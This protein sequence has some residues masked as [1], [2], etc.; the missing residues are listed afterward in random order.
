MFVLFAIVALVIVIPWMVINYNQEK[1]AKDE[2][3]RLTLKQVVSELRLKLTEDPDERL[4]NIDDL[5]ILLEPTNVTFDILKRWE[6]VHQIDPEYPYPETQIE[7]K[8]WI[9]I[10]V[11]LYDDLNK[12]KMIYKGNNIDSDVFDYIMFNS[13]SNHP[14]VEEAIKRINK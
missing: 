10:N 4:S 6:T 1:E 8:D 5:N 7:E 3:L 12:A 2:T 9:G 11:F 13:S 14:V